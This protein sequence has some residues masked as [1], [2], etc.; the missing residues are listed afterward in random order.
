MPKKN[1]AKSAKQMINE[2][3][4]AGPIFFGFVKEAESDDKHIMFARGYDCRRWI[5]IPVDSIDEIDM[6]HTALCG[7]HEHPFVRLRL[8]PPSHP[9][10]ELFSSLAALHAAPPS[11]HP[12]DRFQASAMTSFGPNPNLCWDVAQ[13]RF[14]PC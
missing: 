8:K 1:P 14:I 2:L 10:G 4:S 9:E 13:H 3:K 12:A 7:E 11:M 6:L 5:P